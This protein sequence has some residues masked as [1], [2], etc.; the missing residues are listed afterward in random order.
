MALRSYSLTPNF[1][2]NQDNKLLVMVAV[3]LSPWCCVLKLGNFGEYEK[4]SLGYLSHFKIFLGL[5]LFLE[6]ELPGGE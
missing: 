4:G 1:F 2:P 3:W 6:K 5:F